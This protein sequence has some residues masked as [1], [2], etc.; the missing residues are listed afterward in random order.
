MKS[1][2]KLA[3]KY[4]LECR[5]SNQKIFYADEIEIWLTNR[6]F[7]FCLYK[8]SYSDNLMLQTEYVVNY[9]LSNS[10]V[11]ID[12]IAEEYYITC[13]TKERLHSFF[14]HHLLLDGCNSITWLTK[15]NDEKLTLEIWDVQGL[16]EDVRDY[17]VKYRFQIPTNDFI[18]WWSDLMKECNELF[19]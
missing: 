15:A 7:E 12:L 11:S 13:R 18:S 19:A 1:K 14:N 8:D 6:N 4:C 5:I 2:L 17:N 9:V 10:P 3:K 16:W